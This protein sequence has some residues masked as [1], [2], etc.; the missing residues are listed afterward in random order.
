MRRLALVFVLSACSA[1]QINGES[2]EPKELGEIA[3][4]EDRRSL[5]DG[6][7]V[8]LA[9]TANEPMVRARGLRALGRLQEPE[10]A[11]AIVKGLT[12]PGASARL[13]AAFGIGLF[14]LS[15]QPLP[16]EKKTMLGQALVSA[17]AEE[18]DAKI[19]L[20]L[21]EA[22]GRVASAE[23]LER[24]IDR[25]VGPNDVRSGA[26]IAL[27]VAS[28]AVKAQ[29]PARAYEALP[30]LVRPSSPKAVRFGG[31]Y[32]L[33]MSKNALSR[34]SLVACAEDEASEV[35]AVCVRGLAE[36]GADAD[37]ALLKGLLDD[38]DYRVS[39]E[40]V[41]ALAKQ[42]LKCKPAE[43]A[44]LVALE[45]L[46]G[47]VDRLLRGDS[48]GGAQP[49]LALAQVGLPAN[50]TLL[51]S[52]RKQLAIGVSEVRSPATKADVANIDCRLAAAVDRQR[53]ELKESLTCGFG[54]IAE[55]RRLTLGLRE[56]A[57]G[58][59]AAEVE[60]R[61]NAVK[62]YLTHSS[63]GVRSAAIDLLAE[64]KSPLAADSVRP[65]L[66]DEDPDVSATAA[67]A[68]AQ[69]KDRSA[70]GAI[71]ALA[72]KAKP[73]VAV[74]LAQALA[75]LDAKEAVPDLQ[76][77]LSSP[78]LSVRLATADA[79]SKLTG[80]IVVAPRYDGPPPRRPKSTA[81]GET[82]LEVRTAKGDFEISLDLA[83]APVTSAHLI[84]LAKKGYFNNLTFHRI[85][86][87][88]VAQ[89]GDPRGDG[90][91]GPGYPIRCEINRHPYTR[92]A[93]GMALS[94]KDTGGSQFFVT[95]SAQPHLEGKY[96]VFG[97]V[98]TGQEVIDSLLEGDVMLEVTA[99]P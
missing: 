59:P 86:P 63:S 5:G 6:R 97:E 62:G 91:G 32:A 26:A 13:E 85:V 55:A 38:P 68:S 69:L 70:I 19:K 28:K 46:S 51:V 40:A 33:A 60:K 48:V 24:L 39:V 36:V 22:M 96:T 23:C 43:C 88:F 57:G 78:H 84:S 53:G 87:D 10:T 76:S 1:V 71:R 12:D 8:L 98:T 14:G 9:L 94:G 73:D 47:R 92:S 44:A 61:V 75:E 18:E 2:N 93:V 15:W 31:A 95:T 35:R 29:L 4:L 25:L 72:A 80:Q 66:N 89:G 17:E 3:E 42:S 79:L 30:E 49:V 7:L 77:W 74:G 82:R 56:L 16:D 54:L 99:R 58:G 67:M 11:E 65:L 90:T 64:T 83:Q 45:E 41:R 34:P 37:L 27:G 50:A 52:L 20:T 81:E 21:L